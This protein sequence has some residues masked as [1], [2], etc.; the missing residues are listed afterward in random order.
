MK[1]DINVLERVQHRATQ[2][3]VGLKSKSYEQRLQILNL[4]SLEKRRV[5]GDLIEVFKIVTG[6]EKVE[7][8]AFFDFASSTHNLRGHKY[9]MYVNR[10]RTEIRRNFFS[11]RVVK[12]WNQLP[13]NVVEAESVNSFKNRLD[14]FYRLGH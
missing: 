1:K 12:H 10:S 14:K 2:L 8:T 9:K 4:T 3:V 7:A 5:R 13:S 11:Q 6:R